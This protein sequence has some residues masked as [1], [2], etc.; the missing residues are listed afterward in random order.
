MHRELVTRGAAGREVGTLLAESAEITLERLPALSEQARRFVR[1]WTE[2][3]V[4]DP[5]SA[6]RSLAALNRE[7]ARIEPELV[8]G[9]ERQREIACRLRSAIEGQAG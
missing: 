4:L 7:L 6:R 3:V 5:D 9:L 8:R 2:E 1:R